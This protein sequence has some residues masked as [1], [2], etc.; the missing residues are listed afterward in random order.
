MPKWENQF[1][2]QQQQRG[3]NSEQLKQQNPQEKEHKGIYLTCSL[4]GFIMQ[5]QPQ[6]NAALGNGKITSFPSIQPKF[7]L[8]MENQEKE[9]PL[10]FQT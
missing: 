5:E 10:S 1:H 4:P 8:Q 2:Q 7:P 6:G 3:Q 9:F